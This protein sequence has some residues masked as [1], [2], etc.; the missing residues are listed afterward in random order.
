ME[1]LDIIYVVTFEGDDY[2]THRAIFDRAED[3]RSFARD[4][5]TNVAD[6]HA[7]PVYPSC[8]DYC[9]TYSNGLLVFAGR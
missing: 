1:P 8:N 5:S 6:Y 7:I 9:E 4:H 3:A 2:T